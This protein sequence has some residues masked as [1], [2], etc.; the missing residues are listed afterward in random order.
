MATLDSVMT[1]LRNLLAS[2]N[3]KTGR[4][5]ATFTDAINSIEKRTENNIRAS[6]RTVYVTAGLYPEDVS[7][8]VDEA[9]RADTTITATADDTNDKLTITA[10]NDQASGYVYAADKTASAEVTLTSSGATVTATYSD[11]LSANRKTISKSVTTAGRAQTVLTSEKSNNTLVF[12]ADNPQGTGYVTANTSRDT[13]TKTVSLSVSGGTVTASDGTNSIAKTIATG[14]A[15]TPATTI[16]KNPVISVDSSGVITASVS[17]TQSVTPTVGAGYVSSGTAGTITV[18]G[19]ATKQL[20]TQAAKTVTPTT[21]S[22]RAVASGVYTTGAV[23]VAGDTNLVAGNIKSGVSI[24]GVT[25]TYEGTG[26]IDTCNVKIDIGSLSVVNN[27][28]VRVFYTA[29]DFQLQA[30][31]SILEDENPTHK[32][33]Y[34]NGDPFIAYDY[35]ENP[36]GVIVPVLYKTS[37]ESYPDEID[38]EEPYYYVGT[39]AYGSEVYDKWQKDESLTNSPK[40]TWDSSY[41]QYVLTERIVENGVINI[42][43]GTITSKTVMESASNSS[44]ISLHNV[45]CGSAIGIWTESEAECS[46][47]ELHWENDY[48]HFVQCHD[49]RENMQFSL[50]YNG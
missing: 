33:N 29:C 8:S 13:A 12:T 9:I 30:L 21:V 23:D 1:K 28:T 14:S 50:D 4:T 38:Y 5:D 37:I 18:K 25:G 46:S 42:P 7:K 34:D 6:G 2:L 35:K 26:S 16:T 27:D 15:T 19:S 43:N 49:S 3:T 45:V 17:G 48:T 22:Q 10:S 31:F 20:S 40:Y 39:Y 11:G 36:N 32:V 41:K 47:G 44:E 24:F